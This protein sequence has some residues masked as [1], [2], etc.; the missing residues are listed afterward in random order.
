M[1]HSDSSAQAAYWEFHASRYPRLSYD[2][3][4]HQ[5]WKQTFVPE[6]KLP[7]KQERSTRARRIWIFAKPSFSTIDFAAPIPGCSFGAGQKDRPRPSA[8]PECKYFIAQASILA[9]TIPAATPRRLRKRTKASLGTAMP[10]SGTFRNRH[11]NGERVV[12]CKS[13]CSAPRLG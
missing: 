11:Q 6:Q 12:G 8:M 2:E 7:L 10:A 13:S 9:R 1:N 3:A 4:D 5:A